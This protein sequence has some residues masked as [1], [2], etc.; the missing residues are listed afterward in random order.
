M[1]DVWI[2]LKLSLVSLLLCSAVYPG[3]VLLA[4]KAGFGSAASGSLLYAPS[5]EVRGSRLLGQGNAGPQYLWGR[6]SAR[7][8]GSFVSGASNVVFGS[9]S[10]AEAV[11][12]RIAQGTAPLPDFV[13]TSA[14]GFDPEITWDAAVSQIPRVAKARGLWPDD[15]RRRMEFCAIPAGPGAP[16][17][18]VNLLSCNL[19]L[20]SP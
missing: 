3:L 7:A 17:R 8:D 14:S 9:K 2:S 15:L 11:T 6:P 5:G 1:D 13:Q 20:D 16:V 12:K 18:L 4:A 10:S 19:M